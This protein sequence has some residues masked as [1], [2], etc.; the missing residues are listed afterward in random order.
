MPHAHATLR[1]RAVAYALQ[2]EETNAEA[3]LTI[4]EARCEAQEE[5]LGGARALAKHMG[6]CRGANGLRRR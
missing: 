2:L 1:T 5:S 4:L 6:A 3:T